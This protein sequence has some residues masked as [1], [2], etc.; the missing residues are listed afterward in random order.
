MRKTINKRI[1]HTLTICVIVGFCL[2]IL[3]PSLATARH[4]EDGR[5]RGDREKA[6]Q[7]RNRAGNEEL[8][9]LAVKII[10]NEVTPEFTQIL[11]DTLSDY[12]RDVITERIA[13]HVNIPFE[14]IKREREHYIDGVE[15]SHALFSSGYDVQMPEGTGTPNVGISTHWSTKTC[16]SDPNDWDFVFYA[17]ANQVNPS[18]MR[19]YATHSWVA[20]A[21]NYAYGGVLSTYGSSLYQINICLGTWGVN[22]AGG[23]VNTQSFLRVK[24][25]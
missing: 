5:T 6:M 22:L 9:E 7:I 24:Y 23:P 25:R 1:K 4:S 2:A 8:R 12:Q 14:D 15:N 17:S 21:F 16:D 19:W 3:G 10:Y 13:E 18:S 20:W 11:Y